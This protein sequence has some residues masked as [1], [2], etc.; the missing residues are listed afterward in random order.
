[1]KLNAL[2]AAIGLALF[3]QSTQANENDNLEHIEVQGSDYR[4]TGT[5][6]S[7]PPMAAPFSISH[8][9]QEMLQLRQADS[10]NAALRYV[11]GITPESR[12]T[13]TIFDQYTIRGFESYRNYYDGLEL[14]SNG[15][16]N[17]YPQV[18]AFATQSVEVLKGP[19]SVLYGSTPPGGMVNQ[20]AKLANGEEQTHLRLRVGSRS[21][22]ELG[23]DHGGNLSDSL[24]YRAIALT[25]SSDGQQHTT[26]EER[27]LFA[28][29]VR[30]Q[31]SA[32][33]S[34]TANIYYQDDPKSI[35][36][37]PLH[38]IG[39][40]T[41]ASYGYLD[42]DA[43]AGDS[44]WAN[45]DK[46]VL[47]TGIK[48]EHQL[49]QH[50]S[51]Y[52][53]WRYT[54]AEGLQR[55][56]YNQNLLPD[57][58]SV[59]A[60]SAYM[61][62]ESQHGYVLDNQFT[63][64]F[65]LGASEHRLLFGFEYKTLS[66]DVRYGD[67]LGTNTP[68]ID[69]AAPNFDAFDIAALPL[70]FYT[71]VHDIEQSNRALYIQDEIQ[72]A[73]LTVLAGLR[74]DNFNSDVTTDNNYAGTEY[75]SQ[76][77]IDD[78]QVSG[79]IAAL[80]QFSSGW[81]P[82]VSYSESFEPVAGQDSETQQA[83]EPTEAQQWELGVKYQSNDTRLTVAL[84]DLTKKNEIINSA[85]FIS[86]TQAGEIQ[87]KGI[88][89]EAAHTLNSQVEVLFNATHL[90]QE[91]TKQKLD[92]ALVGKRLVWVADNTASFWLSYLPEQ[93]DALQL[94]FGARYVGESYVGKYN[95]DI[96]PSYTLLDVAVDYQ[97]NANANI[98]FSVS[99][100]TDKRY[101]GACYDASN[102]WMGAERK[103]DLGL[104][105]RF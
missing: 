13:V 100:V 80:Y 79:R 23:I 43:F 22:Q 67:T 33:T 52:S 101:V 30:W 47:M 85:D 65:S 92:P 104:Q 56:T 77:E 44:K 105:Y 74:Y 63:S 16:W 28:P 5:K 17:L 96:V 66:S 38:S 37:T 90:D 21:L 29:S 69:L 84:F 72:L 51:F 14:Q 32:A 2:Y 62:D 20:I 70:D 91:V 55:N 25:R 53:N 46:T 97:L 15:L 42:A 99:N 95:S 75:G 34:L 60:R 3:A 76:S 31:P 102:C 98:T 61:T 1:M 10:V 48:L 89:L 18:D 49:N 26:E 40:L 11:S 86:K 82:Y 24:S 71:E 19:A 103:A 9:D 94:S 50:M 58:E 64:Q 88:E 73:N 8:I 68:T 41:E 6:S 4:S 54:D 87:S 83:F 39:T 78:S 45:F 27:T 7:L 57:S 12:S 35:P 36:S 59:L 93:L 81:R